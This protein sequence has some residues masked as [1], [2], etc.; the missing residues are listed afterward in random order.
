MGVVANRA[1]RLIDR[2]IPR[3]L[4]KRSLVDVMA[5]QTKW[6]L[7][8]HQ[9]ILLVRTVGKM[10]GHTALSTDF[11]SHF[12][13]IVLFLMTLKASLIPFCFQKVAVLRSMGIVTLDAL[14]SS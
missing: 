8:I 5:A 13:F 14:S 6:I 4:L 3:G 11:V 2:I 1:G 7:R 12:L 9:K 10:T